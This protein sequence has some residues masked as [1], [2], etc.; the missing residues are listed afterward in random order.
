MNQARFGRFVELEGAHE[1]SP[2]LVRSGGPAGGG[3]RR[4]HLGESLDGARA[5]QRNRAVAGVA[6]NVQAALG[7]AF[8]AD[9][10]DDAIA[11]AAPANVR[12]SHFGQGSVPREGVRPVLADPRDAESASG[13]LVCGGHEHQG[14]RGRIAVLGAARDL[15]GD[16]GHRGGQVEHVDGAAPP[17]D[18]VLDLRAERIARPLGR[19][20]GHDVRVPEE[21][22]GRAGAAGIRTLDRDHERGAPRVRGDPFD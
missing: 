19:I 12:S 18:V 4:A 11:S 1:G 21:R 15:A 13:F 10:H 9:D 5:A 3:Q 6:P 14:T 7:G 2:D 8:F 16:D 17:H 22:Q 20:H